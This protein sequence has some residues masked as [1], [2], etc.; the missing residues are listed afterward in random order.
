VR[1]QSE[2]PKRKTNENKKQKKEGGLKGVI[3]VTGLP[4]CTASYRKRESAH[5]VAAADCDDDERRDY[6]QGQMHQRIFILP[7]YS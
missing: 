3:L 1:V 6:Q 5:T 2:R 7:W 4:H